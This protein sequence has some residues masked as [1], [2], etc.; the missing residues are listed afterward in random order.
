MPIL[1][2]H[3][4]SLERLRAIPPQVDRS[5]IIQAPLELAPF[6]RIGRMR[7]EMDLRGLGLLQRPVHLLVPS[8]KHRSSHAQA[9]THRCSLDN[10]PSGLVRQATA[11]AFFCGPELT[12]IQMS[13]ETSLLGSVVL[14]YELCGSYSHFSQ[15]ISGFYD[16]PALTDVGKLREAIESVPGM[17]GV[18]TART[19]L[20]WV[21]DGSASPMETVVSCMLSLPNEM[22]GFGM[23]PPELNYPIRLNKTEATIAGTDS[24]RID[25]AY[26]ESLVGVEFDGKDYHRDAEHDAR[27]RT[28]LAHRG[29]TIYVLNVDELVS[30]PRL[31]EKIALLDAVPR[32]PGETKPE[33]ADAKDLLKRLLAATRCGVGL[34]AA[35][36]GTNVPRNVVTTHL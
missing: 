25:T 31:K 7:Q 21:R 18:N 32:R 30:Y 16:R 4:S 6:A 22:G 5:S 23:A 17:R 34:N 36:F 12:F 14:G 20:R 19:A 10:L 9:R 29:W 33:D 8:G 27:R 3:N 1:L 15:M 11:S 35:L 26:P 24:L 28:A 13:S 2:S